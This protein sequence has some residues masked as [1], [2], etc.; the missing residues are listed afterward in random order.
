M[1]NGKSKEFYAEQARK[2]ESVVAAKRSFT[3][4]EAG[5]ILGY[6]SENTAATLNCI[7]NLVMFGLVVEERVGKYKKYHLP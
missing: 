3:V 6:G 2:L 5:E 7:Q 1:N 4:R